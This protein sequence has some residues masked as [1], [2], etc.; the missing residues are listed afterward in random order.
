MPFGK[1]R[2]YA[3]RFKRRM[4][5][6]KTRKVSK[7]LAKAI[8]SVVSKNAETKLINVPQSGTSTNTIALNYLALSGIQY[9][10]QDVFAVPQGVENTTGI[11]GLNRIGDKIQALGFQMDYYFQ[12]FANYGVA[13][14]TVAIPY[15]KLRVVVFEGKFGVPAPSTPLLYDT[16]YLALNTSTLQPIN[17][18]AGYC[19][20]VLHDKVYIIRNDSSLAGN[21]PT[22]N[23]IRPLGSVFHFKKY[24][25][26]NKL[27]Q[28][29]DSPS[30]ANTQTKNPIYIVI[31]AE[32][33]DAQTGITPSGTP[34]LNTTGFTRAWFKD[35]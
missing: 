4:P 22:L 11:G 5:M 10:V 24:F 30:P 7:T 35:S 14:T 28:S 17:Y 3:K 9:L 21:S 25:R 6:A 18:D 31:S 20:K 13:G 27:V 12:P 34:I 1:R 26:Y 23:V 2:N 29:V 16:N 15:V 33:D 19:R 32:L 8:K